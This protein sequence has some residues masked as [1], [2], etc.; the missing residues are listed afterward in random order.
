MHWS[1]LAINSVY[2]LD[3]FI[4]AIA[5]SVVSITGFLSDPVIAQHPMLYLQLQ[6]YVA[7]FYFVFSLSN[8]CDGPLVERLPYN[9]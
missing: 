9:R 8:R 7:Q 2:I 5:N 1:F 3:L 4:I 6:R